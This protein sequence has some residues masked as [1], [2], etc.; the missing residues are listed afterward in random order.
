MPTW[1]SQLRQLRRAPRGAGGFLCS[2]ERGPPVC[3]GVEVTTPPTQGEE[4][5]GGC[6]VSQD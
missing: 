3:Q 1:G 4:D 5:E 2:Q 6:G